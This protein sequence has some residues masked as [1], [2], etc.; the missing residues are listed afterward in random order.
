MRRLAWAAVFWGLAAG[1]TAAQPMPGRGGPTEVGVIPVIA[2]DVPFVATVPG[3]AVASQRVDIRPQVGGEVIEILYE[4]GRDVT[5]GTALFRLDDATPRANLAAAEAA[6]LGAEASLAAAEATVARY[7]R[8]EGSGVSSVDRANAEVAV[9]Q[10]EAS[11]RAAEAGRDQAQRALDQTTVRSPIEGVADLPA[12]SVGDLV[13]AGQAAGLT[14]VTRL[15]PIYVDVAESSARLMQNRAR[16]DSGAISR[17]DRLGLR[18]ILETGETYAAEGQMVSPGI[19]VSATT[20][21]VPIRFQFPNPDRL[22]LPGQFLRVQVTL[23]QQHAMLVPQRATRRGADGS[24]TAFVARDGKAQRVVLT[25]A[26][27]H[28]NAWI[29]TAGVS[30]DDALILDGLANL[31]DGAAI[32]TVPVTID[33]EGVVRTAPATVPPPPDLPAVAA[34][35]AATE[36]SPTG[37]PP[38]AVQAP[39]GTTGG[40]GDPTPAVQAA[41]GMTDGMEDPPPA[42]QPSPGATSPTGRPPASQPSPGTTGGMGDSPPAAQASPGTASPTGRRPAPGN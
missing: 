12:V 16:I 21:S 14:R 34:P 6:R 13:T 42:A 26:G 3:R 8:L 41:P 32:T 40:M 35:P 15:D 10:A 5:A 17:R 23:G 9:R 7:R 20:G 1:A 38:P 33:A 25:E 29:V 27:T 19:E 36:T 24:L 4:P 39:P 31:R 11:L 18:L 37:S 28:R 30:P 22:I 2:E